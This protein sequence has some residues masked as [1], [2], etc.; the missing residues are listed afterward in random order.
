MVRKFLF[1]IQ[2]PVQKADKKEEAHSEYLKQSASA[3]SLIT[4][5]QNLLEHNMTCSFTYITGTRHMAL[6]GVVS[7]GRWRGVGVPLWLG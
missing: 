2:A 3:L 4:I 1:K 6:I 5:H 7:D